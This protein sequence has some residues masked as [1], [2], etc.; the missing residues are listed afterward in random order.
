MNIEWR[1]QYAILTALMILLVAGSSLAGVAADTGMEKVQKIPIGSYT[2]DMMSSISR[3]ADTIAQSGLP[4]TTGSGYLAEEKKE[5]TEGESASHQISF[6][7]PAVVTLYAPKGC[8]FTLSAREAKQQ[9]TPRIPTLLLS[10]VI[11]ASAS[12]QQIRVE[13]GLWEFTVTA[14]SGSGEYYLIAWQAETDDDLEPQ[15]KPSRMTLAVMP[16]MLPEPVEQSEPSMRE[17]REIIIPEIIVEP[18]EPVADDDDIRCISDEVFSRTNAAYTGGEYI[19]DTLLD[20]IAQAFS[21]TL[22]SVDGNRMSRDTFSHVID[23]VGPGDRLTRAGY[24]WRSYA[25]NIFHNGCSGGS[26]TSVATQAMDRWL[27]SEG[28]RRNIMNENAGRNSHIGVGV[29]SCGDGCYYI[30]LLFASPW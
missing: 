2:Q 28:H 17:I 23:G 27:N 3:T 26:C 11:P 18:L 20:G 16:E 6:D 25:E 24:R 19:R 15:A 29:S 1:R 10:D 7:L 12:S 13:P 14:Q 4:E 8:T 22:C 21:Q 9:V 5:L 30:T